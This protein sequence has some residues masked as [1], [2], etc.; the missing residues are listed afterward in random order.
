MSNNKIVP[1]DKEL[2]TVFYQEIQ[3][4]VDIEYQIDALKN[5][6]AMIKDNL[7]ETFSTDENSKVFTKQLNNIINKGILKDKYESELKLMEDGAEEL[8]LVRNNINY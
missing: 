2:A 7:K 3:R 4:I 6:V 8:Q 5:N 1:K